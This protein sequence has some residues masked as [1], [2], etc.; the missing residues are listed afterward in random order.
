MI[1]QPIRRWRPRGYRC[2]RWRGTVAT[3][4]A[5]TMLVVP[6]QPAGLREV[7]L[8]PAFGGGGGIPSPPG[9]AGRPNAGAGSNRPFTVRCSVIRSAGP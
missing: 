7:G 4:A 5:A 6:S 9:R 3:A 2:C 8:P 1:E